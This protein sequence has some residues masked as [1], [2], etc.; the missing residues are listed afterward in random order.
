VGTF[1]VTV[2]DTLG[3]DAVTIRR[4]DTMDQVRVPI[5]GLVERCG[6]LR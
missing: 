5:A 2:D 4:R 1:T 6:R 3:D